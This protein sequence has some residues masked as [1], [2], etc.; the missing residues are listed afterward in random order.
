MLEV[1]WMGVG[2]RFLVGLSLAFLLC[3]GV[4]EAQSSLRDRSAELQSRQEFDSNLEQSQLHY[5]PFYLFSRFDL[6]DIA[7]DQNLLARSDNKHDFAIGATAPQR[8]YFVPAKKFA[9]SLDLDPTYYAFLR[10]SSQ[11][12]FGY[13]YRGHAHFLFNH[14]YLD[15]NAGAARRKTLDRLELQR[16]A[17]QQQRF[18]GA[19]GELRVSSR[20]DFRFSASWSSHSACPGSFRCYG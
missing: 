8:L 5:G 10:D 16:L 9:L 15:V 1:T 17:R 3:G 14:L 12:D 7:Y 11:N 13:L 19:V 6:G 2:R 4:A 20:T 18:Y